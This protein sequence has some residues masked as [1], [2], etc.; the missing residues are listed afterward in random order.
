MNKSVEQTIAEGICE[1]LSAGQ[2]EKIW[3]VVM[4]DDNDSFYLYETNNT[5]RKIHVWTSRYGLE[6]NK[7][8]FF[9]AFPTQREFA[10]MVEDKIRVQDMFD[11]HA[12][13][14]IRVNVTRG[15]NVVANEIKRRLLPIYTEEL[16]AGFDRINQELIRYDV[17]LHAA[18]HL[19]TLCPS[20]ENRLTKPL[21]PGNNFE[22][23]FYKEN[24]F[25]LRIEVQVLR[26]PHEVVYNVTRGTLSLDALKTLAQ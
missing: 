11:S 24:K 22:V 16:N 26:R 18:Q 8:E 13:S 12:S 23:T 17:A 10:Y 2:G 14:S 1:S 21:R 15:P 5:K 6:K 7:W 19:L 20:V 25:D 3:N 9:G 4:M